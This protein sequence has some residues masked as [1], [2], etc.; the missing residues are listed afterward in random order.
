VANYIQRNSRKDQR[1]VVIGSE[2]QIY[3]YSHR[4]SSTSQIYTYPLMEPQPFARQMQEDMIRQIERNPPQF[5][6]FVSIPTSW[7]RK[8]DSS[9]LLLDWAGG[10]VQKNMRQVGLIQ[11]TGPQT[12]EAVWG[13][14]AAA[15]PL[16]STDFVS[17]FVRSAPGRMP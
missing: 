7:L 15:T 2:P 6:V 1:I 12:T 4:H 17:V 3:F 10:Y 11:F 9:L 13:P 5:L 8:P 16:R 14:G